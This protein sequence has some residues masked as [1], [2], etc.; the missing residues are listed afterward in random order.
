MGFDENPPANKK[1]KWLWLQTELSCYYIGI[2]RSWDRL[3]WV[4]GRLSPPENVCA[5]MCAHTHAST[6][7]PSW[8]QK[9]EGGRE[10]WGGVWTRG[11]LSGRS[12][13]LGRV[14]QT[15]I[16]VKERNI[17]KQRNPWKAGRLVGSQIKIG[18][19]GQGNEQKNHSR[20]SANY[21]GSWAAAVPI[22]TKNIYWVPA[23][24]QAL[25]KVLGCSCFIQNNESALLGRLTINKL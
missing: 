13:D 12:G 16:S 22:R 20:E 8:F 14:C 25:I 4:T 2:D 23:T 24:C 5:C 21:L 6:H 19:T 1:S 10:G 18:H 17:W 11:L 3:S 7:T 15:R 9:Q